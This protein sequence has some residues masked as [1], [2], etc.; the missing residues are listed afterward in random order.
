[1][2]STGQPAER[3]AKTCQR[4]VADAFGLEIDV[5]VRTRAQLAAVVR[6]DP[7]GD[8][9]DNPKRYVV[10]FLASKPDAKVVRTVS[11]A[12]VAP[13]QVVAIGREL[14]A[15]HPDGIGRS[16]LAALLSGRRIGI[17][18]TARNWDT[19]TKLLELASD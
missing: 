15:W 12:A 6:R 10:T 5:L 9:A 16:K 4:L 19:V 11:A 13:E 8:V 3:V 18:A 1:V 7:L 14:Y 17:T 2:L